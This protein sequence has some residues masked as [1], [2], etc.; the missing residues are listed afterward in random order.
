MRKGVGCP[1]AFRWNKAL[2]FKVSFACLHLFSSFYFKYFDLLFLGA[3]IETHYACVI[4]AAVNRLFCKTAFFPLLFYAA[5]LGVIP[6]LFTTQFKQV[7]KCG[8]QLKT[9]F[10][11]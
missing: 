5:K 1:A 11:K 4:S 2:A 6:E 8:A 3:Q 9:L 7:L 10:T